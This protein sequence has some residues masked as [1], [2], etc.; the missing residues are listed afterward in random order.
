MATLNKLDLA[1]YYCVDHLPGSSI[2][3][4]RLRDILEKIRAGLPLTTYGFRYLQQIGLTALAQLARGEVSYEVFKESAASERGIREQNAEA[5]R[6]EMQASM[7]AKVAEQKARDEAYWAL[8]EAERLARAK[9][10][11]YIARIKNKEIRSRYGIDGFVEQEHFSQLM[12]ILRRLDDDNRLADDDVLW[13]NTEGKEYFSEHLQLAFHAREAAFFAEEYRKTNDPWSAVN[14]SS[15]YRK[16]RQA[17][18]AHELLTSIPAQRQKAPKLRSA[19]ATTHGGVMRDLQRFDDAIEFGNQ[20]HK[21][22]PKDFRPCTLL[23]AV[24]FELGNYDAGRDWYGKATELGASE[25]S[26]EY[27]LRGILLRADPAKREEIRAFLLKDDPVRY[28]WIINLHT[29]KP[30]SS[31]TRMSER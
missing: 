13:L 4:S 5:E 10:P 31:H 28:R 25:R 14:A 24:N 21:L 30:K 29:N 23:G 17:K 9:D 3:A 22:T 27:D 26:I 16:C 2:P 7:L 1:R 6:R 18:D 11:K 8:R 12:G 15:H 19:I 20:A